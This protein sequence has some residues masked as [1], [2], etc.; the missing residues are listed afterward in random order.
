M[1]GTASYHFKRLRLCMEV[2]KNIFS[3][4]LF[5]GG[6]VLYCLLKLNLKT[7]YVDYYICFGFWYVFVCVG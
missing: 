6:Y 1:V 3:E 4:Y 5:L 7:G 2:L